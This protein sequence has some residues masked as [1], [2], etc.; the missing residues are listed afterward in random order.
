MCH[1]EIVA[2]LRADRQDFGQST[3]EIHNHTP[4][5]MR[6][7]W[8]NWLQMCACMCVC[9]NVWLKTRKSWLV[10]TCS[11]KVLNYTKVSKNFWIAHRHTQ[12]HTDTH[13]PLRS[14]VHTKAIAHQRSRRLDM[15]RIKF[16][17]CT[18]KEIYPL[19]YQPRYTHICMRTHTRI[20]IYAYT[21]IS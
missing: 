9:S 17:K 4:L 5:Y 1:L 18:G 15:M 7:N 16:R 2:T 19:L 10:H 8:G 12:T 3:T 20:H 13:I 6:I 14:K 21:C 11:I